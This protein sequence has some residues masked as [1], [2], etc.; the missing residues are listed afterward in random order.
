[1]ATRLRK[2]LYM[3]N[4]NSNPVKDYLHLHSLVFNKPH[5]C[6]PEYAETVLAVVGEKFGV[7][8][9]AYQIHSKEK[10][11]SEGLSA[12]PTKVIPILGSLTHRGSS[13]GALSGISS[14]HSL[15][16]AINSALDDDSVKNILLD[17]D[18]PGGTVAGAF[19]FADF[20]AESKA[21]K[22]IYAIARD[23]M[24]S[25]AYLIGSAATKVYATQTS[26]V[27]SIGVVAMHLDKSEK[28]K[29]EG[30]KPT[31]IHA[32]AYKVAGNPHEKLEGD[33]LDYLKGSVEESYDMFVSAVAR[34]RGLN[35]QDVR[36][37]EAR[38]YKGSKAK[39]IGLVDEITTFEALI[40]ELASGRVSYKETPKGI[41]M[42]KEKIEDSEVEVSAEI[43]KLKA[44]NEQLTKALIDN[45]FVISAEGV[46]K[47]GEPEF[48]EY[49]GE[50]INKS[51]IPSV[52]LEALEAKDKE[53]EVAALEKADMAL[54]KRAE[55][56]LPHFAVDAAKGLLLALS[57]SDNQEELESALKAAD[58][59]LSDKMEE[60]GKSDVDGS[61]ASANDK[62]EHMVK[63]HMDENSLTKKD[64][65]KAYAAVAKTSEG[66]SLIAQVYKGD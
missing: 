36:D 54:T 46:E 61:F 50:Q 63:A 55:E 6:T 48:I 20:I 15:Q 53:L 8:Q 59:A 35:E 27:G 34:N 57:K 2:L 44:T 31:F 24:S 7:D 30:V 3:E 60:L 16:D 66:K 9:S 13:M 40:Q 45:G 64:Y 62:L 21:V 25:A 38:V 14:Y 37:T 22:P 17:I 32:G 41:T 47:K 42:D 23:Q 18:S 26:Q 65:A 56:T 29:K 43:Q 58:T 4:T 33:A 12:G 5:L 28:D 19:D 10:R 49:G 52:I 39:E 51:E 11:G 1:M